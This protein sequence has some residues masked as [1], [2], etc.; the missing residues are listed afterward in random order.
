MLVIIK[1]KKHLMIIF[2]KRNKKEKQNGKLLKVLI[3]IMYLLLF[4]LFKC[5]ILSFI[6]LCTIVFTI[7]GTFR[8]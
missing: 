3:I 2:I 8:K 5:K 1:T 4:A 6:Q 7:I